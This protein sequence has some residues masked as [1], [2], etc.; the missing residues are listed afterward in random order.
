[1]RKIASLCAVLMLAAAFACAQTR[2]LTGQVKDS[3][4]SPV[5][6]A[7]VV[8]K[9]TN[10]GVSS[11][12]NGNF[13][14]EVTDGQSLVV[15]SVGFTEQEINVGNSPT[16]NITLQP[17]GSLQ[18]VV[19]TA[20]GIRRTRNQLPFAAQQIAGEEVN[21]SRTAN[22]VQNLSGKVAGLDI[23]QTNSL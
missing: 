14:I 13:R 17:Q 15:S 2:I 3:K 21:R 12:A 19:V 11:D 9:G 6:F 10:T 22:F 16:I 5:P 1:M 8:I 18:E 20:L 23:K 7:N 4:G